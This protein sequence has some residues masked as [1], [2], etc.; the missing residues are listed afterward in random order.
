ML[1]T[2]NEVVDIFSKLL[3]G[4]ITREDANCWACEKMYAFDSDKLEFSP[5]ENKELL[6]SGGMDL[7]LVDSQMSPD[8]YMYSLEEIDEVYRKKWVDNL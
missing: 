5:P 3:A 1:I 2:K 7:M 6:W 4:K 8:E